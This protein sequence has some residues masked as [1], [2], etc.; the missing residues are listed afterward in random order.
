M[1]V[2]VTVTLFVITKK[3]EITRMCIYGEK[4]INLGYEYNGVQTEV[5]MFQLELCTL[6]WMNLA[7]HNVE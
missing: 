1:L 4:M 7:S 6:V 3:V 5:Q 2:N